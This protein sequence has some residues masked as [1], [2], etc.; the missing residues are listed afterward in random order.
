MN[1][2][3]PKHLQ[4]PLTKLALC[5][6][7]TM[8]TALAW[9]AGACLP[10]PSVNADGMGPYDYRDPARQDLLHN[11]VEVHHFNA[12]VEMARKGMS[13]YIGAE[14][15]F[16]LHRFPNHPRAL[17][18]MIRLSDRERTDRP[19]GASETVECYL[20]RATLFSPD[21]GIAKFVYGTYLF[22]KQRLEEA[23]KELNDANTLNPENANI[24][25]N[26]GLLYLQRKDYEKATLHAKKA[27]ALGFSL[28]GLREKLRQA[29]VWDGS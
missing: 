23:L 11:N 8:T 6:A 12:D 22:K 16:V 2:L 10:W 21:D 4:N 1:Y 17:A 28:P 15:H 7:L 13:A 9:G 25:Y 3:H 20:Y 5:A 24:N 27:Y 19:K 26:L 14:L 29:G 18:A